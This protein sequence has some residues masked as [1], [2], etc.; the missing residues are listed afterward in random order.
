MKRFENEKNTVLGELL[1]GLCEV[2]LVL[3]SCGAGLVLVALLPKEAIRDVPSEVFFFLGGIALF[4][5][6]MAIALPIW[7]FK[8]RGRDKELRRIKDHLWEKFPDSLHTLSLYRITRYEGAEAHE[9]TVLGG[10]VAAGKFELCKEAP[11][12]SFTL[13]LNGEVLFAESAEAAI[14]ILEAF[15]SAESENKNQSE[16]TR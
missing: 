7:F 12:A 15:I 9:V 1:A 2:L 13:S 14:G 8:K 3:L 6:S 4:F 11:D 5:L 16:E 10:R